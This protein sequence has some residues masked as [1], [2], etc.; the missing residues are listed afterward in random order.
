MKEQWALIQGFI[1]FGLIASGCAT[2]SIRKFDTT[3]IVWEDPDR[4]PIPEPDEYWSGLY[5]DGADKMAFR[6]LSH[7]WLFEDEGPAANTNALDEVPNSSWY[8]NRLAVRDISPERITQASCEEY[9]DT[10]A[11]WLVKSGKVDGANP[12]FQIEDTSSG[13][14]YLLKF[15][16]EE[17][18]ERAT[19]ADVIGS[20]V[21]WAAG[22]SV[23]C[24]QIVFFDPANLKIAED[25]TKR[26]DLGRKTALTQADV[27]QAIEWAPVL[28]DGRIRGSASLFLPGKPLG[29]FQYEETRDDDPNDVV[30][31]EDRRELRGSKVIAAWLNHFDAR[32]QNTFTSFI[33]DPDREG[34]GYVQHYMLDWGDCFGSQWPSDLMTRRFG[35]SWYFHAGHVSADFISLG[36]IPRPWDDVKEYPEDG[37][38]FGYYDVANFE[39]NEWH[40]GYPHP[41]FNRADMVD[42][43][44]GAKIVS[45]FTDEHVAE[46]VAEGKFSNPVNAR[47]LERTLI[48]RRDKIVREYFERIS[49]FDLPRTKKSEVCVTDLGVRGGYYELSD[50]FYEVRVLGDQQWTRPTSTGQGGVCYDYAA[51][52][53]EADDYLVLEM[54]VRRTSQARPA[55]ST[56]F[57]FHVVD[58]NLRVAGIDRYPTD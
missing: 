47:Y 13:E 52:G 6:P 37:P 34:M 25:A 12:G 1:A 48:G 21:Y 20:K 39:P 18:Q 49:P 5:W 7:F 29:P 8:T 44:W 41:A 58:G 24:N 36:L 38:I 42:K 46:L 45:R 26:D 35:H 19:A 50:S 17:Q 31:H 51:A 23:P 28:D 15:D 55:E 54:R 22:F 16:S 30:P 4:H 2:D 27:E 9:I 11:T 10:S 43:F 57:H 40:N 56:K 32:E 14:R 3:E 33:S 53:R